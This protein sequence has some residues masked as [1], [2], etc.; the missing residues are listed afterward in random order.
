MTLADVTAFAF[1]AV[2]VVLLV[3]FLATYGLDE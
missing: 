3:V 1:I 2:V